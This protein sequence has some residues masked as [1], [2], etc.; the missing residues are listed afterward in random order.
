MRT[1]VS[2]G[3]ADPLDLKR[4]E[5]ELLEREVGLKRLRQQLEKLDAPSR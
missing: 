3:T 2:V 4:A 1:L 5:V